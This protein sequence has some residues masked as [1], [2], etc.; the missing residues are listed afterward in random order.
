MRLVGHQNAC[1]L[2][3]C[4]AHLWRVVYQPGWYQGSTMVSL[5]AWVVVARGWSEQGFGGKWFR[6]GCGVAGRG[7]KALEPLGRQLP[8]HSTLTQAQA[9]KN[10]PNRRCFNTPK[11][12]TKRD[13]ARHP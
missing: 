8:T 13:S 11:V 7:P 3:G 10:F 12:P 2:V 9:C 6:G 5:F 4:A 1:V